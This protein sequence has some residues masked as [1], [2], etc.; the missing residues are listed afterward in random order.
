MKVLHYIAYALVIIG[1]I[2]WLL[3]GIGDFNGANWN[4]VNLIFGSSAVEWSVYVLVG[5]AA[6][7]EVVM[8]K[9]NCVA[10]TTN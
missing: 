9:K 6:I 10:C 4:I 8:H 3:V 2:N 7:Y 5:L 1:A